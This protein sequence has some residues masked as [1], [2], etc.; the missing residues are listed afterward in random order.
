[1]SF[2]PDQQLE[3]LES[4][5]RGARA[6]TPEL[7]STVMVNSCVRLSGLGPAAK[8]QLGRLIIAGA[9]VDAALAL[10]KLELPYWVVRRL[11]REDDEWLCT[12][13]RQPALP[14][15]FDIV[16]EARHQL[17]P[18]AI[19]LALLQARGAF[20]GAAAGIN[21]ASQNAGSDAAPDLATNL[22]SRTSSGHPVLQELAVVT[23]LCVIAALV[24]ICASLFVPTIWS[25]VV[26]S[27][28]FRPSGQECSILKT[29]ADRE[30]C[31][32]GRNIRSAQHPA[33]GANAPTILWSSGRHNE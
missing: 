19:L 30:G 25:A 7:M 20:R 13:S 3:W 31:Y 22:A 16:A 4:E 8:A 11:I 33:K 10:L 6:V 15:E 1:M 12:L 17:L 5:L 18:V 32:D 14:L 23:S 27:W 28:Q 24:L 21:P 29:A 9:W 2:D 26:E